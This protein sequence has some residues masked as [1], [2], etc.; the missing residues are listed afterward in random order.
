M[1]K[2]AFISLL[3]GINV[4][5][6]KPVKMDRLR[7]SF[8]EIGFERVRTYIQSGNV[9]FEAPKGDPARISKIIEG[10]MLGEFGFEIPVVTIRAQELESAIKNNPFLKDKRI[11]AAR[12]YVT[13]LSQ[14]PSASALKALSALDGGPDR[15]HHAAKAVYLYCPNGYGKTKLSNNA[16]EKALSVKATTRNWQTVNTLYAMTLGDQS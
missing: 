14:P 8:E 15:L 11:D 16:I 13:F 3:R 4:G 1:S 2:A 12:L 7:Q 5:G 10:Q 6:Q 9:V